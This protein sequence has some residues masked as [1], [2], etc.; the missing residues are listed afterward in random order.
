MKV[1][2]RLSAGGR[3]CALAGTSREVWVKIIVDP[4]C[5]D[6][7]VCV[8]RATSL[9]FKQARSQARVCA[10]GVGAEVCFRIFLVFMGFPRS[11]TVPP[12]TR[13]V[14]PR[15]QAGFAQTVQYEKE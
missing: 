11:V 8:S 6:V 1:K 5:F 13:E 15:V 12:G 2:G 7:S 14:L 3:R 9:G 4:L 10:P